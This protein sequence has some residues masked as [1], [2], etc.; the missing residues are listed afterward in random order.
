MQYLES[1][2]TL[3]FITLSFVI[4][5][6]A[7]FL[8][9]NIIGRVSRLKTG[10]RWLMIIF[11][12]IA[13]GTG[14]WSLHMTALFIVT[15]PLKME[16]DVILVMVSYIFMLLTALLILVMISR[17]RITSKMIILCGTI[18]G[19]GIVLMQVCSLSSLLTIKT[20]DMSLLLIS[21]LVAISLSIA[22]MQLAF[23]KKASFQSPSTVRKVLSGILLST[24]VAMI[25]Y[26]SI[27]AVDLFLDLRIHS[28]NAILFKSNIIT[29]IISAAS[30]ITIALSLIF[31]NMTKRILIT[32]SLIEENEKWFR[33]LFDNNRDAIITVDC[34]HV[35]IAFNPAAAALTGLHREEVLQQ[36]V[37]DLYSLVVDGER[38]NMKQFFLESF[39]QS[40]P[41]SHETAIYHKNGERIELSL[42]IVPVIIDEVRV[43]NYII[44]KDVT[45]EKQTQLTIQQMAYHDE[46]TGLPNRRMVNPIVS[47]SIREYREHQ[48]PF[49]VL[50][51]DID[52]FKII[53]DSLGHAFGDLFL[54]MVS[55]R[56]RAVI[57]N[58]NAVIIRMGGDEFA[59][60][61]KAAAIRDVSVRVANELIQAIHTPYRLNGNDFY[62]T[63]SIGIAIYP[64]H[65][66]NPEQLLKNADAAMYEVKKN[67]KNGHQ[68]YTSDMEQH[69]LKRISIEADLR[70][71]I[72]RQQLMV[73][74]QPQF[75]ASSRS[76]IGFEAL[77]RWKHPSKGYISPADF[78]P[79]AEECGMISE[80][81]EW[82]LREACRQM[83]QWHDLWGIRTSI[84]VNLS[85]MQFLDNDLILKV[86]RTLE[87]TGLDPQYL[88]L[89]ITESMMMDAARSS[90][91]L[92]QLK[93][94][95]VK[96]SMDDFGTGYSSLY[97]LKLFPIERLKIDRSFIRDV[98]SNEQDRAIVATII[99][100]A[101]NLQM[102]VIAEGVETQEQ[103]DI[104]SLT[105]CVDIQGYYFSKPLPANEI[106]SVFLSPAG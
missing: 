39:V 16:Y 51:M 73:H 52:R 14:L 105:G 23:N 48:I 86:R 101:N 20:F 57:Q 84:A 70:K 31:I 18:I 92:H 53:N 26:I 37:M 83:K 38:E 94:I 12:A 45:L 95:G 46:L 59:I 76:I 74:Y 5:V 13:L 80:I 69:M 79:I 11:S 43:G 81:G 47:N 7:S 54:N 8:P 17:R 30:L 75:N 3:L 66:S 6:A 91:T 56:L 90:S 1:S 27:L 36:H 99:S 106:E 100:M 44:A 72:N 96:I 10:S 33:C 64:E 87:D 104:L 29:F 68:L 2:Y 61:I 32:E 58:E 65:G 35:I 55:D 102:R 22:A 9:L 97:Y 28:P 25:H 60:M 67:G 71:A 49:A 63:A 98:N 15:F 78:I 41:L 34:H 82:A 77:L 50:F 88:E 40:G 89:E 21:L 42:K 103:L 24:A 93:Q 62:I 4:A 85:T 19:T